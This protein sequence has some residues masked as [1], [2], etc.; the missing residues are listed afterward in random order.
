MKQAAVIL[1][2]CGAKDGSEIHEATLA[3]Y[4]LALEGVK[5]QIFAPD[6]LQ[7]DVVNHITSD[8]EPDDVRNVMV[9]AARIARGDIL[10]LEEL[11]IADYDMLVIPGGFGAAKNLFTYAYDGMSFYVRDD[12][13]DVI[14]AFHA[15]RKPIGAMCIAPVMIAKLLGKYGV[16]LT[17]GP[18]GDLSES[19]S[20]K[21]GAKVKECSKDGVIVDVNNKV[22]TTPAYMYGSNTIKEIGIGAHNMVKQLNCLSED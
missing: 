21:F 16:E 1:A 8:D 15:A 5:Y 14:L 6:T 10:S 18:V 19:V 7:R 3:L 20:A 4:A 9:E 17:L 2:G 11:H 13:E 22:V 12:V